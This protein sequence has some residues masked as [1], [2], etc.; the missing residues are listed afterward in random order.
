M[1]SDFWRP[2]MIT[3]RETLVPWAFERTEKGVEHLQAAGDFLKGKEVI[4]HKAHRFIDSDL[5]K[6]MEGAAYLLQLERDPELEAKMDKIIAV[7]GEAQEPN[8][9]LYPSH[10]TKVGT[11]KN[12]MG[13]RPYSF[14]VHSHELYN[15]G[16]LYEAAVAYF[17]TTGKDALLKIAEKNAQHIN[18]VF[19]EGDPKYNAGKAIRQAPGHQE[20]ELALV[21]L[22]RVTGKQLYLDMAR[23]FLEIR[24]VTYVPGGEGVMSPTYAQQH[25]P[26]KEQS[27]AVGHAVRATYLY[28][29]MA[30]VGTLTGDE[31]YTKALDRIW[32][33]ITDTRM[34]ITGGLGAVHGIEGFGPKY[35]LPNAHAFNETCAAVGNVLLNHRMFLMKKDAKYID[36]AEVALLNNV[37]AAVNLEGNKFFYVNPLDADGKYPFNHGTAGRAPWFGTACCPSNIARLIPQVPGM[38][39]AH[40]EENL[41]LTF[42]AK[43]Q[44]EIKMG[45]TAVKLV[46]ETAYPNDG[47]IKVTIDPAS[48]KSFKLHVRIPTWAQGEQF[49][50]GDLYDFPEPVEAAWALAVNGEK[51][52]GAKM[53]NGFAVVERVWKAGDVIDLDL[54]MPI[55]LNTCHE[56]VQENQ[57]RVAFTRGPFVMCAEGIDNGGATQRFFFSTTPDVSKSKNAVKEIEHGKFIQ[58]TVH[59]DAIKEDGTTA[60]KIPLQ[61]TPY[62]AWNNRGASSMTVWFPT[63]KEMAIFDPLALPKESVFTEITAS[64]TS[65]EDTV[66]AIGD[67]E[68]DKNSSGNKVLR[69]TSRGQPGKEQWV[70]GRF[71]RTQNIRSV[72]VFWMNRWQ[73]DVKFPKEWSLEVE[74]NGEWK[75][76]ELYTTDKY[77]QQANQFNLVHPAAPTKCDAIRINMTPQEETAVGIIE[78]QVE[79]EK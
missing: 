13:D 50:P 63:E 78:V 32:G 68:V 67:G 28:A 34:H 31:D 1:T 60:A 74:Q 9:Y 54:P 6:V 2:R 70:T 53:E 69:W 22:Y 3:Q 26:V 75:P 72:G 49:V 61:L 4:D 12:M 51:V 55:R 71:A 7:I 30:D 10:T 58:S 44:T 23:K 47:A 52:E 57:G 35:E 45:E 16:H 21:K 38:L 40:D 8:G 41:Y 46:Q 76:F 18:K 25:K 43:N 42:Y 29:A 66:T 39:Y 15:M 65:D 37:L 56:E 20:P 62:Y 24:G 11:E 59:A 64:H 17:E 14:V 73:A 19:F 77:D 48:E 5:Y 33:N 36:I 27:E 79:F